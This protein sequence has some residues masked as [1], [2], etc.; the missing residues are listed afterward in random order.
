MPI[1]AAIVDAGRDHIDSRVRD[2][3]STQGAG[4]AG[5][6]GDRFVTVVSPNTIDAP[7][8][9]S[10][11]DAVV[12]AESD[13]ATAVVVLITENDSKGAAGQLVPVAVLVVA[14]QVK[15]SSAAAIAC[16]SRATASWS[17]TSAPTTDASK[18]RTRWPAMT[19]SQSLSFASGTYSRRVSTRSEKFLRTSSTKYLVRPNSC[20]ATPR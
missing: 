4:V 5:I 15:P 18:L 16:V 7:L 12:V 11:D 6:V 9:P 1:A 17:A 19:V 8:P 13:G 10:L 3:V 14:D 2:F 20:T